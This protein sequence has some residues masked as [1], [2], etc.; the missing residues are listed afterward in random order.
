MRTSCACDIHCRTEY[1]SGLRT[2]LPSLDPNLRGD[3][4]RCSLSLSASVSR[5]AEVGRWTLGTARALC[6]ASRQCSG[7]EK[8]AIASHRGGEQGGGSWGRRAHGEQVG[9]TGRSSAGE[10]AERACVLI[11]ALLQ[12]AFGYEQWEPNSKGV[13]RNTRHLVWPVCNNGRPVERASW[14]SCPLWAR[15]LESAGPRNS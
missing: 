12:L 7:V 14:S 6:G 11:Q 13:R 9:F 2:L 5:A 1:R 4:G 10:G 8:E 15:P 3:C